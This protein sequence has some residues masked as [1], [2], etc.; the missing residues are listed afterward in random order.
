VTW[1]AKS[2][3]ASDPKKIIA[4]LPKHLVAI[5][6]KAKFDGLKPQKIWIYGS[7]ARGDARENSDFDL[8]FQIQDPLNWSKFVVDIAEDP[9]SLFRYDLVDF[10]RTDE[11]LK[12]AI[13]KEGVLIYEVR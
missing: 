11:S 6:D 8:A 7:R 3:L 2:I 12:N 13:L 1:T 5:I 4:E 9:P 10:D